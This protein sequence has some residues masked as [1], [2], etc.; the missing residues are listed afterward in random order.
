MSNTVTKIV[1]VLQDTLPTGIASYSTENLTNGDVI[2]TITT[3]KPIKTPPGWM[4]VGADLV[5]AQYTKTYTSNTNENL[6]IYDKFDNEGTVTIL[7]TNIDKELPVISITEINIEIIQGDDID[8]STGFTATDTVDGDITN[9]VTYTVSPE[10]NK[11]V[12]GTYTVTYTVTDEAGNTKTETKTVVVKPIP[13]P[14][15]TI[16]DSNIYEMNVFDTIPTL[17]AVAVDGKGNSITVTV[18]YSNIMSNIVGV[19]HVTFTAIDEANNK[20]TIITKEFK[21]L[22]RIAPVITLNGDNPIY[23]EVNKD[24]YIELGAIVTDNY[25]NSIQSSLEIISTVNPNKIGE[26]TVT[27]LATDSSGNTK[28]ET[29][30]VIVQDKTAPI[31]VVNPTYITLRQNAIWDALTGVTATDNYDTDITNKVTYTSNP[32]LDLS[33][34][35]EYLITYKATDS[36]RKCK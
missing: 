24:I 25:D 20:Q 33:T 4:P 14:E 8:L 27:Y 18:D 29:R 36:S 9:K 6:K 2:V 22:D 16:Q 28:E 15:I 11:N 13:N 31:I 21:V 5:P 30:T 12:E 1:T 19:Y 3:N 35:G 23:I 17:N 26:Y 32:E 34:I 10:F 7:I